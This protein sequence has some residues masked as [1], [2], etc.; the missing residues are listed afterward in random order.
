MPGD[1][2]GRRLVHAVLCRL[3]FA[4]AFKYIASRENSNPWEHSSS[5]RKH[6]EKATRK[7]YRKLIGTA[8]VPFD[9]QFSLNTERINDMVKFGDGKAN[10]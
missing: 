10:S 4:G 7:Q 8:L 5:L 2:L 6:P 1:S 9:E 3:N